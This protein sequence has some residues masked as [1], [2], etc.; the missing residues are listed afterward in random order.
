[1]APSSLVATRASALWPDATTACTQWFVLVQVALW[2]LLLLLAGGIRTWLLVL[3]GDQARALDHM[4]IDWLH[5]FH[6]AR[7]QH[8]AL[9]HWLNVF[10]HARL[11]GL[12]DD[13]LLHDLLLTDRCHAATGLQGHWAPFQRATMLSA[14]FNR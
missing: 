13:G 4:L 11:D 14:E 1:M 6:D 9:D 5:C 12:V 8:F 2:L 3:R 7:L 10:N